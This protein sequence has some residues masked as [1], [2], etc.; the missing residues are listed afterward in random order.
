LWHRATRTALPRTGDGPVAERSPR[1]E[2]LNMGKCWVQ[3]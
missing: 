2:Y 1:R 3:G